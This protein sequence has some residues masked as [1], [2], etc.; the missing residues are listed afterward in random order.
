MRW[1]EERPVAEKEIEVW[2][3]YVELIHYESFSKSKRPKNKSY[4]RLVSHYT[5]LL[6]PAKLKYFIFVVTIYE[7]YLSTF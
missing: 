2:H 5:D 7:P 3:P 4:E 6:M 1:I